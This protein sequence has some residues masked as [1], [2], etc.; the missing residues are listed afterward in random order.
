[1]E[2]NITSEAK[3]QKR[4]HPVQ[5]VESSVQSLVPKYAC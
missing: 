1:M 4:S 3:V 5:K 2:K